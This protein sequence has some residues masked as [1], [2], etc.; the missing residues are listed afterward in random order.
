MLF[1]TNFPVIVTSIL[2]VAP[3]LPQGATQTGAAPQVLFVCEHGAAKSVIAAAH[4]N[5]L[6]KE[7][8][9]PHRAI[10]RGTNPDPIVSPKVVSGLQSEGLTVAREKPKLV[11]DNEVTGATRIITLGCKLPQ[12]ASVTDWND[13][14]PVGQDFGA[15]SRNIRNHVERLLAE[16]S[17]E[18]ALS[19]GK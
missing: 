12:K 19:K 17:K 13:V 1:E 8:G 3:G 16:L 10:A 18:R 7:R 5:K 2:L 9:L 4:F 6:A 15:A 11:A 14:P